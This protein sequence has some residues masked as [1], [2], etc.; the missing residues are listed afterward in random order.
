MSE[1][2]QIKDR[3][4]ILASSSLGD[5]ESRVLK[6]GETFGLFD[7]HGDIR[8]LGFEDHGLYHEGTRY[9]S[10]FILRL[11]ERAPLLLNSAVKEENDFLLVHFTNPDFTTDGELVRKGT[12]HVHR[13]LFIVNGSCHEELRFA[14][15]GLVPVAFSFT[16]Q[17]AA[18]YA[19]IFEVRGMRRARRG[20]PLP[21]E[22]GGNAVVLGYS[23]LDG[24]VRKTKIVFSHAPVELDG[25]SAR[26]SVRLAPQEEAIYTTAVSCC[27]G[28]RC[29]TL[30]DHNDACRK[31][32]DDDAAARQGGT[33][34][35]TSNEGFNTWLNRSLTDLYMMTT[36]TEYGLY[37]FAGIPWYSTVFGRDGLIT[38][39]E[40][41]WV[42]PSIA[43]GVLRYLAAHQAEVIIP[44]RDA[45]PGKI[46]HEERKGEMAALRE[47]PFGRY[48]GT[49]DATPLFIVL[50]G[51]YY[52]RTDDLAFIAELWPHIERALEWIDRSGDRDGDG[53]VEYERHTGR[54]LTNQGWKDSEDA[55]FH[56][57][58]RLAPPAIALCEVQGYVYAA[59]VQAC[60]MAFALGKKKQAVLLRREAAALREKFLAAFW[61]EELGLYALALDGGKQRC[62]VRSSNAGQCLFAG[63]ATPDHANYIARNLMDPVFFS[64]WGIRTIAAREARYNPMSYHNGSVWPHD[65][66]L[67]AFGLARYGYKDAAL[68]LLTGM[69]DASGFMDL[70]RLPELFCG[71]ARHKGEGP[72]LYPVACN[73]QAWASG[74]VFLL[75]QSCVGLSVCAQERKVYFRNPALPPFLNEL[76]IKDLRVGDCLLEILLRRH[77]SDVGVNVRQKAGNIEVIV[78]K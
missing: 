78:T 19:D 62:C 58:G 24:V 75:L 57:D 21:A 2:I 63:I 54:G 27:P 51:Y 64:G 22:A 26:F 30:L 34:I 29:I 5:K 6:Q 59:K 70:R 7:R 69:F 10:R 18:D 12:L 52:E 8:P 72:T 41:L 65:N 53:F 20:E 14:N 33:L 38:A 77:D 32:R 76:H 44:D 36:R 17:Y 49:V 46:V 45:E 1:L 68:R 48:Y 47:I 56:A 43:Q 55:V 15:F 11:E 35:S 9:L 71:F 60:A 61:C 73:P 66:A 4:Y 74:A 3:F 16:L 31:L 67:I 37:P 39:L 28:D 25:Q 40:M 13:S 42:N 50:A 23:G